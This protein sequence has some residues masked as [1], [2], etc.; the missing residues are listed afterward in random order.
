VAH[1][2]DTDNIRDASRAIAE[3]NLK[4]KVSIRRAAGQLNELYESILDRKDRK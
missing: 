4:D 3:D 1:F 2:T